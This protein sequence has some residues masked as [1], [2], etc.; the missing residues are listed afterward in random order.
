[1]QQLHLV[2]MTT[3]L[4]GL[5]FSARRGSRSGGFVV[6]LD[7][8]LIEAIEQAVRMNRTLAEE[9]SQTPSLPRLQHIRVS[10][11]QS[12]LTPRE[13][14]SRLRAGQTI[15]QV[16]EAAGVDE[17]WVERF[18]APVIAEQE[19]MIDTALALTS[20]K[21]RLGPS[22]MNLNESVRFNLAD[23]GVPYAG[24]ADA[25]AAYT[26]DGARW[27]IS[28]E[29]VSRRRRHVAEWDF[30]LE[31]R[32]LTPRNRVA[33][34][35]GYV[36]PGRRRRRPP[37]VDAEAAESPTPED[38]A[39][40]AG[41][42]DGRTRR[43]SSRGGTRPRAAR[44]TKAGRAGAAGRATKATSKRSPSKRAAATKRA[45]T[46]KRA[47]TPKR[48]ATPK[49]VATAKRATAKRAATSGR[50]VARKGVAAGRAT[51]VPARK[52]AASA[53][54]KAGGATKAAAGG[55]RKKAATSTR[56]ASAAARNVVRATRTK[57]AASTRVVK[58]AAGTRKASPAAR[59]P[60]ANGRATGA[61]KRSGRTH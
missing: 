45:P 59:A 58:R 12:S 25:W 40:A 23:R 52:R 16:A 11:P 29:Y 46:A 17:D 9:E 53:T 3:E 48:L 49:R 50:A 15:G 41:P 60:A 39:T 54:K 26:L 57:K 14:Q 56:Q 36:E 35:I 38:S 1:M 13:M 24:E 31:A 28:F 4:D 22:A 2:G 51:P 42:T 47:P 37:P 5:I 10:R 61:T 19:R 18:A 32:E 34:D 30:D 7:D 20:S 8:A 44:A 33:A 27:V 43:R 55:A 21:A 6:R